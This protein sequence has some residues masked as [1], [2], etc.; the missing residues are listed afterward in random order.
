MKPLI[1][2]TTGE[3]INQNEPWAS[4]I[5]GQKQHYSDA[6]I[7]AGGVPVIIPFMPENELRTLYEKLDGILFAG[8]NDIDPA[9]YGETQA[10]QTKDVSKK[11]DQIESTLMTWTLGDDKPLFAICRGFQFFNVALGGTLHQEI[12]IDLPH[13][14]DHLLTLHNEDYGVIA[15]TLKLDPTSRF[16]SIINGL[17]IGAN[18]RHHQAVNHV[19][20]ELRAVAWSEDGVI[21]ALEHPAKKFALGVQCHPESLYKDDPKWQ[22]VF[23]AFVTA[24]RPKQLPRKRFDLKKLIKV[25]K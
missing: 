23:Q 18:S 14:S 15:H 9:L 16:A 22:A 3:I 24:T 10:P 25:K 7:A 13:A 5:Y 19:A 8:G 2:I 21:E 12:T 17:S 1:G 20:Q 11:R 6:I 4:T